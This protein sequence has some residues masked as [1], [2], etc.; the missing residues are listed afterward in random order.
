MKKPLILIIDDEHDILKTLQQALEDEECRVEILDRGTK[1]IETIG[2]LVPDV[3]FLDIFMPNC[4]GLELLSQIKAEYPQQK[5]IVISGFGNIPLAVKALKSGAVDFIEKPLS[6]DDILSK[7]EGLLGE[8]DSVNNH[9]Y[10]TPESI[11]FVGKSYTFLEL[12]RQA[13]CIAPLQLPVIIHGHVGTG[14]SKLAHYIH[15][16]SRQA[17]SPFKVV[18]S[19]GLSDAD[20]RQALK[21][22]FSEPSATVFVKHI[23]RLSRANQT[24]LLELMEQKKSNHRVLASSRTSLFSLCQRGEFDDVLF[25]ILNSVPLEVPSLHK[26]RYDIPLLV[27]HFLQQAN[28]KMNKIVVMSTSALRQLRNYSWPGNIFQ[29]EQTIHKIVSLTPHENHVVTTQDLISYLGERATQVIEEQSFTLFDSLEEASRAFEK[30]F[31]LHLL[32]SHH[33]DIN[34]VSSRLSLTPPQLRTKLLELDISTQ[35]GQ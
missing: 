26:H 23:E 7:L 6:L 24:Y 2:R 35:K 4:N 10:P 13:T 22:A 17:A 15:T 25:H 31:L 12:I 8:T 20:Q 21:T 11:N 30:T 14:K 34:Q 29:L 33:Y 27:D 32:K 18:N 19:S 28:K 9:P 16:K 5:V 3:V 1:A